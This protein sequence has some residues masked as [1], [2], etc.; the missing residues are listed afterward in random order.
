MG[1]LVIAI[2]SYEIDLYYGGYKGITTLHDNH[3][4][5][6]AL[7]AKAIHDRQISPCTH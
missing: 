4:N 2:V 6:E 5:K 1:G 3:P 7:I